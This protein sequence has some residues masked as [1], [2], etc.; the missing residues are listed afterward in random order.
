MKEMTHELRKKIRGERE[1]QRIEEVNKRP[2]AVIGLTA[3]GLVIQ[4]RRRCPNDRFQPYTD[5]SYCAT[6]SD[7]A[8]RFGARSD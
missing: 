6:G 3:P 5:I 2:E 7:L 4:A 1:W 8:G